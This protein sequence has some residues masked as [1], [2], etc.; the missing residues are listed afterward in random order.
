MVKRWAAAG[1]L[2]A[3]RSFRRVKVCKEMP[4]LVEALRRHVDPAVT[5]P[6]ENERVA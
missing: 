2:N 1:M 4:Q 5:S 6:C 3:E